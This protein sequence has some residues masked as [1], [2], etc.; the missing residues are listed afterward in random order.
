MSGARLDPVYSLLRH[1]TLP[2]V[3]FTTERDGVVNGMIAN[4]AQRASLVPSLPRISFYISKTNASHDMVYHGGRV[5]VH[6][7]RRDQWE[8]IY[9]LGFQSRHENPSKMDGLELVR[10]EE[11]GVPLLADARAAFG[12]RVINAMDAGAS[13]FFLVDVVDV[14]DGGDDVPVMTSDWFRDHLPEDRARQYLER[15][16]AAQDYL[17]ELAGSVD[18]T[19]VWP[20]ADGG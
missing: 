3:A 1:L 6:L 8:V 12:C 9:R 7:L 5:G 2:V 14:I 15:L 13:T 20:G 18:R 11:T 4:S 17:K 16:G 19:A 10:G